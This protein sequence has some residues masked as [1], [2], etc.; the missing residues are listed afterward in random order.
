MNASKAK[1]SSML[2]E[3]VLVSLKG[4]EKGYGS[5]VVTDDQDD[6]IDDLVCDLEDENPEPSAEDS[7]FMVGRW[8]LLF[9]SSSLTRFQKGISGI[10]SLLPVGKSMDLEQ[11]IEPEDFRS[12]LVEKVSYF[13]GALK[14]DALIDGR[15]K[16][17]SSNRLSWMPDVLN[18]WFLRF[19]AESGWKALGAFRSLEVTYLDYELKIERGE[20]GQIYIWKRIE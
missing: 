6:I 8:K 2:K 20:V 18:L 17:L 12:Y 10:H 4:L 16:W 1:R 5:V 3:K 13:G 19:Q 11:V 14:G 15:Y 9:T 7:S